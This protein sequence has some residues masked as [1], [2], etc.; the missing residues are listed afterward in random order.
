MLSDLP[1]AFFCAAKIGSL[2][3]TTFTNNIVR[4]ARGRPLIALG[5]VLAAIKLAQFVVDPVPLFYYDSGAYIK[6]AFE[7]GGGPGRSKVYGWIIWVLCSPFGSLTPLMLA[8]GAMGGMSAWLLA[9]NLRRYLGVGSGLAAGAAVLFALD[10]TQVIAEHLVLTE[11]TALFASV[12]YISGAL[13]YLRDPSWR[14]LIALALVGTVLISIKIV[15]LPLVLVGTVLLPVIVVRRRELVI[16]LAISIGSTVVFHVGYRELMAHWSG[17]QRVYQEGSGLFLAARVAP[18]LMPVDAI[19]GR[20]AQAVRELKEARNAMGGLENLSYHDFQLW[21]PEGLASRLRLAYG[22]DDRAADLAA[23][24]MA[25]RAILRDPLGYVRLMGWTFRGF[26]GEALKYE[27][28]LENNDGL[29]VTPQVGPK[30]M[31]TISEHFGDVALNNHTLWTPTRRYHLTLGFWCLFQLIS[32][33]LGLVGLL[34]S[35]PERRWAT[36]VVVLWPV[37]LLAAN[38]AGGATSSLR[39]LHPLSFTGLAGLALVV[40]RLGRR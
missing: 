11:T 12:L 35:A 31:K 6:N 26:F 16:A 39:Y 40:G 7:S 29:A 27:S 4:L 32:P 34:L 9:V 21:N 17:G 22:G 24:G 2:G 33:V 1:E 3:F 23:S 5:C 14:L 38:C 19:D 30:S 8:Q 10:P 37:M 28:H 25:R 20:A 18:I 36:A 13:A 15:Y